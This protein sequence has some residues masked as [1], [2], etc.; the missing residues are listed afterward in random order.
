M[1]SAHRVDASVLGHKCSCPDSCCKCATVH[2]GH[3]HPYLTAA[4]GNNKTVAIKVW[5]RSFAE[6][7]LV[8]DELAVVTGMQACRQQ[9][10]HRLAC[11][12]VAS[13]H[14]AMAGLM[15][16]GTAA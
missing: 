2:Q 16:S 14:C 3:Y 13:W 12:Q 7:V 1:L 9:R 5:W 15:L 6:A 4:A 8:H 11:C 10:A